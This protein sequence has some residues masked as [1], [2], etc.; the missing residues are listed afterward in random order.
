MRKIAIFVCIFVSL[1]TVCTY[2]QSVSID[3]GIKNSAEYFEQRL[4]KGLA[5]A[6]LTVKSNSWVLSDYIIEEL[7]SLFVNARNF[8]VVDRQNLAIV[9]QEVNYQLSGEVSDETA[10]S[11][12]QRIGAQTVI[13]G[14]IQPVDNAYRLDLRALSVANGTIQGVHRQDIKSDNRLRTLLEGGNVIP[15]SELWKNNWLYLGFRLGFGFIPPVFAPDREMIDFNGVFSISCQIIQWCAIQTELVFSFNQ[16]SIDEKHFGYKATGTYNQSRLEIP[17]LARFTFRPGHFSFGGFTGVHFLFPIGPA[18]LTQ[19]KT[20]S[21]ESIEET[22]TPKNISTGLI[23]GGFFGYHIGPGSIFLDVRGYYGITEA[24]Y[25]ISGNIG[26]RLIIEEQ[27]KIGFGGIRFSLGYE[28]G[29]IRK[30]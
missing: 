23:I 26:H 5:I 10:Q 15:I 22:W 3:T 2:A 1:A 7:S 9:Q 12:G 13:L 29:I 28:I 17:L 6:V 25:D 19:G 27:D 4:E 11:I 21:G 18:R 8:T 16:W 30:R 24:E 14:S 20:P